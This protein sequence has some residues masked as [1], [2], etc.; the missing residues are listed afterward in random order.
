MSL[1]TL[2]VVV[3]IRSSKAWRDGGGVRRHHTNASAL[4]HASALRDYFNEW[5]EGIKNS[6]DCDHLIMHALRRT[7][8]VLR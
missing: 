4:L 3:N 7:C 6:D 2:M 8:L 5:H 1:H